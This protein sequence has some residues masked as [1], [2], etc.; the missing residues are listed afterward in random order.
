M[1]ETRYRDNLAPQQARS[2]RT[3]ETACC[4]AGKKAYLDFLEVDVPIVADPADDRAGR[5]LREYRWERYIEA[6]SCLIR[7]SGACALAN[8]CMVGKFP[9]CED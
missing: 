4:E 3:E 7:S 6:S 2:L 9:K 1:S 8:T 5:Q